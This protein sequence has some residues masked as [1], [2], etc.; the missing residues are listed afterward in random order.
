M[1]YS[2]PSGCAANGE[3]QVTLI[4]LTATASVLFYDIY[5]TP[6]TIQGRT[7]VPLESPFYL[8]GYYLSGDLVHLFTSSIYF[9]MQPVE[10]TFSDIPRVQIET[11]TLVKSLGDGAWILCT[12]NISQLFYF[13]HTAMSNHELTFT[14]CIHVLNINFTFNGHSYMTS[15]NTHFSYPFLPPRWQILANQFLGLIPPQSRKLFIKIRTC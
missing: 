7:S 9:T 14:A 10:V 3:C 13:N 12:R 2:T 8:Q 11:P 15:T 1:D 5:A 6:V 4:E